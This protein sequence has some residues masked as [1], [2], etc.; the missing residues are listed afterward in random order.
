MVKIIKIPPYKEAVKQAA[1]VL[2]K[3][4]LLIYPTDTLYGIGGDGTNKKVIKKILKVKK[5]KVDTFSAVVKL[6]ELDK[7]AKVEKYKNKIRLIFPGP[8]TILAKAKRRIAIV[9]KN[10]I[11]LRVPKNRFCT[12]LAKAFN[13]P[14]ISTSAN[15]SGQKSNYKVEDIEEEIKQ[16]VD[17]I[18]DAGECRHKKGSTIIDLVNKKFVR[19]GAGYKKAKK[20]FKE[21]L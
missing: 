21:F 14:I 1:A 15:I 4:G 20:I 6:E 5:R 19:I 9:K 12:L 16:K 17:L 11:G 18:I 7:Y 2:K 8:F 3:G 13:R 10:V